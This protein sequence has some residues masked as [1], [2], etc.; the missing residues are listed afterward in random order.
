[1]NQPK[2]SPKIVKRGVNILL[3]E[4]SDDEDDVAAHN[5]NMP[6]DPERPWVRHFQEYINAVE[7][8]PD[9]WSTIKWW[10]VSLCQHSL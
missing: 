4:L 3:R 1:M 7:Q 6:D 9:G 5:H 10:G 2:S 8:V